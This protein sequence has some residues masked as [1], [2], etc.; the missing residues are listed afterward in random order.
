M[1][2]QG[3]CTPMDRIEEFGGS[4]TFKIKAVYA[5][6]SQGIKDVQRLESVERDFEGFLLQAPKDR[7]ALAREVPKMTDMLGEFLAAALLH[8]YK[9]SA[10]FLRVAEKY[11]NLSLNRNWIS[12]ALY[13]HSANY[14]A[15]A[16][17]LLVDRPEFTTLRI[18]DS[19]AQKD[20]ENPSSKKENEIAK[21]LKILQDRGVLQFKQA[22]RFDPIHLDFYVNIPARGKYPEKKIDLEIDGFPYH[23]VYDI[24]RGGFDSST[25]N[26]LDFLRD[27]LVKERAELEV[28]RVDAA[29]TDFMTPLQIAI[30]LGRILDLDQ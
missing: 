28:I 20:T 18:A 16:L 22:Y 4:L 24:D 26:P 21:A 30:K 8:H 13:T 23:A 11:L 14:A 12:S 27:R 15:I 9:P 3:G 19:L 29:T 10:H 7:G 25:Q 1:T 6:A 17:L 2:D 5:A